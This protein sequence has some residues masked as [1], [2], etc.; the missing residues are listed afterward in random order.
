M[1]IK[2]IS[3]NSNKRTVYSSHCRVPCLSEQMKSCCSFCDKGGVSCEVSQVN[4]SERWDHMHLPQTLPLPL[5]SLDWDCQHWTL[6]HGLLV[7][8][9][10]IVLCFHPT[11]VSSSAFMLIYLQDFVIATYFISCSLWACSIYSLSHARNA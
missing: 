4:L 9:D 2:I 11:V 5:S 7:D 8:H 1:D 3:K 6:P 10:P